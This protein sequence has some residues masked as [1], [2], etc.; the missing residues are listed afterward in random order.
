MA[1]YEL[2]LRD[3]YRI[4]RR[5]L[6]VIVAVTIGLGGLSFVMA[7]ESRIEQTYTATSRVQIS[8]VSNIVDLV[9]QTFTYSSGN[10]I[11]TQSMLISSQPVLWETIKPSITFQQVLAD[12][13]LKARYWDL[14]RN[15]SGSI[16][17]EQVE[18]SGLIDIVATES[19]MQRAM[20]LAEKAAEGFKRYS[21]IQANE[22]NEEAERWISDRLITVRSD[23]RALQ[24]LLK[25]VRQR[26]I[27]FSSF[28]ENSLSRLIE[29][30]TTLEDRTS[31]LTELKIR[32]IEGQ[33]GFSTVGAAVD[34]TIL[35]QYA[36]S[37]SELSLL[38][39]NRGQQLLTYTENAEPIRILQGPGAP[40]EQPVNV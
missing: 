38:L 3:Y 8:Q 20:E 6:I 31:T 4:L 24:D 7:L 30:R 14:I 22:Q 5:H 16:Q 32:L 29:R 19:T 27:S 12:D 21:R 35:T 26:T 10:Y 9:L 39:T 13:D 23:L 1:R 36:E 2:N 40:P 18:Y 17:A 37:Y 34:P 28:D 33:V 11:A 25:T 15:Y